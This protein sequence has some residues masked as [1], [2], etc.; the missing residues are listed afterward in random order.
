MTRE[1]G[2]HMLIAVICLVMTF[3]AIVL[4]VMRGLPLSG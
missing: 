1:R 2:D 3:L 4:S